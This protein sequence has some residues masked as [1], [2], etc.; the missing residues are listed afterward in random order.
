MGSVWLS[1]KAFLYFGGTAVILIG[2]AIVLM[3]P[4][5][6]NNFAVIENEQRTF[7]IL[8]EDGYYPRLEIAVSLRLGNSTTV[9]IGFVLE[10]NSTHDTY[11]VNITLDESNIV[12][13]QD[14]IFLE[15]NLVVAI[16]PGNYTITFDNIDGAGRID[17]GF[18]QASDSRLYVFIGG[19]MNIIGLIMGIAGYFVSG[20]FLPT[21]SDTIVEW[22]YEEEETYPGN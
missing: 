10:E 14:E 11:N 13:S 20:A 2:A 16:L 17:I 8:D 21:D 9:D 15:D 12:E 1:K 6:F 3:A 19:S 4:Y 5:H 18:E 22:G 7:S